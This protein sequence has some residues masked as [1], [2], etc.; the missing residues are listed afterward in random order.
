[1]MK[2]LVAMSGGVDSSVVALLLKERGYEVVGVTL[3]LWSYEGR[4]EPYN[5]CCSLEVSVVAQQLGIEHHFLDRGTPFKQQVVEP[6][7][8]D[9]LGGR[10]PNPCIRCNR[11]IR[12]P[13]LLEHASELGC[14]YLATGHHARVE[15]ER[16]VFYLKKG[17]DGFKDQSYFLFISHKESYVSS[18]CPSVT[19]TKSKSGRSRGSIISSLPESPRVKTCAFCPRVTITRILRRNQTAT[20]ARVKLSTWQATSWVVTRGCRFTR[21]GRE[22]AW[23]SPRASGFMLWI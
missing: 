18:F 11:F 13:L 12:F 16:G 5:E 15:L 10:T 7:I 9:Y 17:R 19:I 6:F 4:L 21:L 23:V 3:N 20:F 8:G 22:A 14:D 1:M 2:V